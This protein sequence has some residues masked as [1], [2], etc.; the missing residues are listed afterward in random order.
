MLKET[1]KLTYAD[2]NMGIQTMIICVEMVPFSIFF[3]WAYN[4]S[5]YDLTKARP[6]PLSEIATHSHDDIDNEAGLPNRAKLPGGQDNHHLLHT[7]RDSEGTY[8]GGPLGVKAWVG[9]L[10]P[11]EI[12]HAIMFAFVMRSEAKKMNL[13][14][15]GAM[16]PPQ[17]Y[18]AENGGERRSRR[19]QYERQ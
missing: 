15:R 12:L 19:G 6:L 11:R 13:G 5:A 2:V 17:Y 3:H 4:V 7:L 18:G 16:S 10:D 14:A 1:S 8:Q 9:L